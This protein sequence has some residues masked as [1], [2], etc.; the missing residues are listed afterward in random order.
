MVLPLTEKYRPLILTDI[1]GNEEVM[2]SLQLLVQNKILPHTLFYGPPGT[3]KTTTIRAIS[4]QLYPSHTKSHVLELNASDERGID[5]VREDIK[6]FASTV[7]LQGGQKLIIL[8]EVDS[9]SKDGQNALRRIIEDFSE[10]TRFCLIANYQSKIIPALQSRCTK[11]RFS[12]VCSDKVHDRISFIC[13]QENIKITPDGLSALLSIFDGDMRK[14]IND[15]DGIISCYKIINKTHVHTV[16]G[17]IDKKEYINIYNSLISDTFDISYSTITHF[18]ILHSID[19]QSI[20]QEI[21]EVLI[22][23]NIKNKF[24]ILKN[25]SDIEYRLGQGCSEDIQLRAFISCFKLNKD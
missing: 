25:I 18:K 5:V 12:P 22:N 24:K 14:L 23:E 20:I 15:L 7:S 9:M 1:L 16:T 11:F 21:V 13:H 6:N 8:D 2:Y 17:S 3:G 19:L 4:H 10:N